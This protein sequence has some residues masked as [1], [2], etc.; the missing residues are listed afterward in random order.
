MKFLKNI[1]ISLVGLSILNFSQALEFVDGTR[2]EF[3]MNFTDE[4]RLAL[5]V[6]SKAIK[7]AG[8]GN[9][10]GMSVSFLNM[11]ETNDWYRLYEGPFIVGVDVSQS[12]LLGNWPI[13]YWP[14][15]AIETEVLQRYDRVRVSYDN[16]MMK[17]TYPLGCL[18]DT[19]LRYG[20]L[21]GDGIKELVVVVGNRLLVFSP[22]AEKIV[23]SLNMRVDDW[24]IE[25]DTQAHLEYYPPGL[26][27]R[28]IPYFQSGANP[29]YATELPG[30]RGY[31]KMYVGD[32][33]NNGRTDILVWRKLYMSTTLISAKGFT[34]VRDSFYHF[35]KSDDGEYQQQITPD[36]LI[37]GWMRAENLTWSQ[38]FPS[39]SECAGEEGQLIPE[40]HDPLLNDPDVLL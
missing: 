13:K 40:M 15:E 39:K 36:V 1:I 11:A 6:I 7:A 25:E 28:F 37:E 18:N 21:E 30:Y 29:D 17:P 27:K 5:P 34:N 3:G 8:L 22:A 26:E 38:G 16:L 24:M 35:E 19:P 31:G 12:K 2:Q 33:D 32:Y 10:L 23:F 4:Q 9:K 20:D 14:S